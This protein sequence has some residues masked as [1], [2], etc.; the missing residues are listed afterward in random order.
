MDNILILIDNGHGIETPGKRSPD[1]LF[2]EY[3]YC[4]EIASMVVE[5]LKKAGYN[6]Q[7]LVPEVKDIDLTTRV[8]RVNDWCNKLGTKNVLVVS[9]HNNAAGNGS[10][11]M[12]ATGWEAWTSKGQTQGDKL[13]DCLYDAA[14]LILKPI[15]PNLPITKLI[16]TDL[17]DGDRDKEYNWDIVYKTKC[18]ACLTENFFQDTR[19]DVEWLNS[20]CGKEAITNLHVLGI[21]N[22]INLI[23]R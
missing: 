21:Q 4:R 7:L 11:W 19:E 20:P 2:R 16:R 23:F 13:A 8:K 1:G 17:S 22:Y 9:I 12:T 5:R 3:A 14:E 10:Q 15:F 6:A 18:A